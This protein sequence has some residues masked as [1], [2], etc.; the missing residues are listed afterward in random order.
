MTPEEADIELI[1]RRM[2]GQLSEEELKQFDSRV[3]VDLQFAE[4]VDDYME[5]ISGIKSFHLNGIREDVANWEKEI[6]EEEQRRVISPQSSWKKYLALAAAIA[7]LAIAF[8]YLTTPSQKTNHELFTAY[9]APYE[10]VLAVRDGS[11]SNESLGYAMKLY[12]EREYREAI[13]YFQQVL[14]ENKENAD[15]LYYLGI[16]YL[17]EKNPTQAIAA[18]EQ[19]VR[20]NNIYSDQ[21]SWYLALANL[22]EGNEPAAKELLENISRDENHDLKD[23]AEDLLEALD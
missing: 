11:E 2:K 4:K 17:A 22:L 1:E 10:N 5:I 14:D 12:D 3:A 18:F 8:L 9:F 13:P 20:Q 7:L 15:A 21:A 16:S 6:Q 23:K 19:L